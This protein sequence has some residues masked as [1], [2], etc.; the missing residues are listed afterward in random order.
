MIIFLINRTRNYGYVWQI[1]HCEETP[2]HGVSWENVNS[3]RLYHIGVHQIRTGCRI[4]SDAHQCLSIF[5]TGI[6]AGGGPCCCDQMH[7]VRIPA[8]RS[9]SAEAYL[10]DVRVD[11]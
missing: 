11:V 1:V 2:W 9:V 10:P 5:E 6:P 7:I 8:I 4:Q 3:W